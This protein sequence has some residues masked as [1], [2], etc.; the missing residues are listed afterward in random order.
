MGFWGGAHLLG[1]TGA[2]LLIR[3]GIIIIG[4]ELAT[5]NPNAAV[6][7]LGNYKAYIREGYTYFSMNPTVFKILNKVGLVN[8]M[9][10][11]FVY[12]QMA[13][14]KNMEVTIT[15]AQPGAYTLMEIAIL[16]N[17]GL[18][19]VY[20]QTSQYWTGYINYF[21]YTGGN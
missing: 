8:P 14:G 17:S 13:Q 6:V 11:Q 20:T 12:N 16:Q 10:Q 4:T 7:S 5:K 9:N 21:T 3:E 19:S 15:S 1:V 18:Y 2:T